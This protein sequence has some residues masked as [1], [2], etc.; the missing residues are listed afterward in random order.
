MESIK[1][2]RMCQHCMKKEVTGK[3]KFCSTKCRVAASRKK[4]VKKVV[5]AKS[6]AKV[7]MSHN[8]SK[9]ELWQQQQETDTSTGEI[10]P[11]ELLDYKRGES[12]KP[13][14]KPYDAEAAM[15]KFKAMGL[16]EVEWVTSGI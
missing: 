12:R 4:P 11:A 13:L 15:A 16:D 3:S 10:K 14:A 5:R 1:A 6:K 8:L 7:A 2:V 9:E